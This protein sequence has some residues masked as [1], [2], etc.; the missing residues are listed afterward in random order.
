M[1]QL[2]YLFLSFLGVAAH[3]LMKAKDLQADAKAA[4]VDFSFRK[5]INGDWIGIALSFIACGAW[6]FV[7]GEVSKQYPKI[8]NY[9]ML[10]FFGVGLTGSYLIQKFTSRTKKL[11]RNTVDEKTNK[12]DA[13]E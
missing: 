3:C 9:V 11:I 10:S 1:E 6:F 13:Q 5:Y 8:E 7:F 12:A 2:T 4:N